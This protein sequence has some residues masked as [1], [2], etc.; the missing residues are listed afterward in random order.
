[1]E[2]DV[3]K[4]AVSDIFD[5]YWK[6]IKKQLENPEYLSIRI[7]WFGT[8]EIR[9][10]QV[11]Y[12]IVKYKSLVKNMKPNTYNKHAMFHE[13]TTKLEQL[14]KI[15]V[16]CKEQELRKKQIREIQKNGKTV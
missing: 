12:M 16:K 11:E 13:V 10:K 3:S 4:D 15:L 5:Y 6:Q 1:L 14:E 2:C 9:K 8:F 7:K